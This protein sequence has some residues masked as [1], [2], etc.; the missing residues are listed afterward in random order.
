MQEQFANQAKE[1]T[2]H[3]N[4][5]STL[6][7]QNLPNQHKHQ[8]NVGII[9]VLVLGVSESSKPRAALFV[10]LSILNQTAWC[11]WENHKNKNMASYCFSYE[12]LSFVES[13]SMFS[14]QGVYLQQL[15]YGNFWSFR[16]GNIPVA[17]KTHF[18]ILIMCWNINQVWLEWRQ[19]VVSDILL[20]LL[21][22]SF[23]LNSSFSR[24][25]TSSTGL[26]GNF[27]WAKHSVDLIELQ[28]IR[29][30]PNMLQVLRK[31]VEDSAFIFGSMYIDHTTGYNHRLVWISWSM[32]FMTICI[33]NLGMDL[34]KNCKAL[35]HNSSTYSMKD[36]KLKL[37]GSLTVCSTGDYVIWNIYLSNYAWEGVA[38][39][40]LR[41]INKLKR[42]INRAWLLPSMV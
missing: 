32:C 5:E 11:K 29:M 33:W 23:S 10:E 24:K 7:V 37:Q 15:K 1:L 30:K 4:I 6:S 40:A 16:T 2:P 18:S 12:K 20:N 25:G 17:G 41:A 22:Y 9:F 36:C 13:R 14:Q 42:V 39:F 8:N 21:S 34:W 31:I 19:R 35:V 3:S 28:I 27:S 26:Y 38:I